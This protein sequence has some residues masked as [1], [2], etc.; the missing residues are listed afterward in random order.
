GGFDEA[1]GAGGVLRASEDFDFQFRA[2]RAGANCLY[3]PRVWVT[4][5][6]MRS[7][8]EWPQTQKAYG[9][10]DAAFYLKHVRCGDGRA[11]RLLLTRV[12]RLTVREA[13]NP[14]R[15]KP[16][17]WHYLRS[18]ATGIRESMKYAIDHEK[19]LYRLPDQQTS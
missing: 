4:H 8:S 5:Y 14:I 1:L 2:M 13:L 7:W 17:Q 18:Y 12:A 10:G 11:L 9:I 19:R 15:R 3:T 6:G 16:S